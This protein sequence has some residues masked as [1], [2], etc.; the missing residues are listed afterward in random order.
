MDNKVFQALAAVLSGGR[1]VIHHNTFIVGGTALLDW[2]YANE[3]IVRGMD[4]ILEEPRITKDVD[5]GIERKTLQVAGDPDALRDALQSGGWSQNPQRLY[6]WTHPIWGDITIEILAHK[7]QGDNGNAIWIRNEENEKAVMACATLKRLEPLH[8]LLELCRHESIAPYGL[9]R[10]N[11][12]GLLLAKIVAISNVIEEF[13]SAERERRP[14]KEYCERIGKDRYDA[15][16]LLDLSVRR[17]ITGISAR[18][19]ME[20]HR[21]ELEEDLRRLEFLQGGIPGLVPAE[22]HV[23]L[24]ILSITLDQWLAEIGPSRPMHR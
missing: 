9:C 21:V 18:Q 10:F 11:Q 13:I 22:E 14:A 7:E 8:G 6:I 16:L 12:L 2:W 1:P 4:Q 19:A 20:R 15:L 17:G 23:G 3:P 24:R 5:L